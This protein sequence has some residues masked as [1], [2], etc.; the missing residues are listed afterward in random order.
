[1]A[2]IRDV[3]R[4]S[5]VSPMTVTNV[6]H[7]RNKKVRE[8]T[9]ERVLQAMRTLNYKPPAYALED[10]P[11]RHRAIGFVIP[12]LEQQGFARNSY[13]EGLLSELIVQCCM[14][15]CSVN[16]IVDS[17]SGTPKLSTRC[18][19]DGRCDGFVVVSPEGHDEVV[20]KLRERA[21]SVVVVGS[22][23]N[24]P[25]APTVDIDYTATMLNSIEH[26]VGLGH[27]RIGYLDI[28]RRYSAS[29]E[30]LDGYLKG[31]A[32]YGRR[33][34]EELIPWVT[35]WSDADDKVGNMPANG[36]ATIVH[37]SDGAKAL[38]DTYERCEPNLRPTAFIGFND[39]AALEASNALTAAGYRCPEH[40][41]I[42]GCDNTDRA[43]HHHPRLATYA[44][45]YQQMVSEC[46]RLLTKAIQKPGTVLGDVLL[47]AEFIEGDSTAALS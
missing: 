5:G 12:V 31:L 47:H 46:L 38:V 15:D 25:S 24:V 17:I 11:F 8:A 3:A 45:P 23:S 39:Y 42:I 10:S 22:R 1:M 36:E 21:A 26:L 6:L 16:V 18:R 27:R 13:T 19:Y 35:Q 29:Y 30:R 41:S 20:E 2:T 34:G 33:V 37:W 14:I 7:G 28:S 44:M 32:E 4:I 40:Y 9:R 43:T